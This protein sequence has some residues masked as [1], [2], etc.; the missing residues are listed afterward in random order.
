MRNARMLFGVNPDAVA[1]LRELLIDDKG[2]IRPVDANLLKKFNQVDISTFCLIHGIYQVP[3]TQLIEWLREEI[4]IAG[5]LLD[6]IEIGAGNGCIGRNIPVIMTDSYIQ[7]NPMVKEMYATMGQPVVT[8]STDV[9]KIDGNKAVAA[10]SPSIVIGCWITQFG[11][12]ANITD[13]N[14]FGVDEIE[15]QG[16]INR[17]I[18]VGNEL[19]HGQKRIIKEIPH[20][21]LKFDWLYSRSLDFERNVIYDF[22]FSKTIKLCE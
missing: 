13:S 18:M 2:L 12:T 17:Y 15:F 19:T 22:D 21:V 8:Y 6:V 7:E 5:Q 11:S 3:T 4:K 9:L 20:R 10:F 16:C 1:E 14:P